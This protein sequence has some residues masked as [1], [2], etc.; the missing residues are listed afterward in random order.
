ML[1]MG[2]PSPSSLISKSEK[3]RSQV[4]E[5][6]RRYIKTTSAI[7]KRKEYKKTVTSREYQKKF[8]K[9]DVQKE[10][11]RERQRIWWITRTPNQKLK[12]A[13]RHRLYCALRGN[14]KTGSA[15][16]FLGCSITEL[17]LWIESQWKSGMSWDNWS[18]S[19]WHLDHKKPLASFNLSDPAQLSESCHYKNIQPL[20]AFENLIKGSKYD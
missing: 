2:Q 6:N 12:H 16:A 1:D 8:C 9:T 17:K 13:L 10:K 7:K 14:F 18:L 5:A 19:G 11:T 4:R 20:W 15:V 3:R